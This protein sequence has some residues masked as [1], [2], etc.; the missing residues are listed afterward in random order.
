MGSWVRSI[1]KKPTNAG[2]LSVES[3]ENLEGRGRTHIFRKM[4]KVALFQEM[5]N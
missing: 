1:R 3:Q 2:W 4:E 5:E